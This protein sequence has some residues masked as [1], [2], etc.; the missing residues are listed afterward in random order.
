MLFMTCVQHSFRRLMANMHGQYACAIT[1]KLTL[2][3]PWL[4]PR[5]AA[6]GEKGATQHPL[7]KL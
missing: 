1:P 3:L 6:L 4:K 2:L 7:Y 5:R